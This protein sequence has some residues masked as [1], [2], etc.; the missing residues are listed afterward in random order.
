MR[1]LKLSTISLLAVLLLLLAFATTAQAT[2]R[3]HPR[4]YAVLVGAENAHRG[5][6]VMAFFPDSITIHVGDTVRWIQNSNEIHTVTFLGGG[7][8]PDLILPAAVLGLPEDPSPL[9]FNPTAVNR[10]AAP[11][12]L[13]DTTTFVN[14]GLM[15]REAGQYR[16]FALTFR[17]AGTYDYLCL[18]HGMMMSGTVR[19]VGA[20]VPVPSPG[21]ALARGYFQMARQF[22][23][24]P[25]VV[26]EAKA[27][28]KPDTKNPDGTT[29]HH[30]SIGFS[31]GQ[32][33]LMRFFPRR[34]LV[35]PGDTVVWEMSAS[36]DAPHTVTFLNGQTEPELVIPVAQASGPP[37]LYFN[38]GALFP[39]Q[40]AA[41]LTRTG[42]YNSGIMNP[43]PG[44][45]YTQVIG[46]VSPGP[47]PYL[48]LLHDTSGMRGKLVVRLCGAGAP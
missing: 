32:I 46:D 27:Q 31:S 7:P 15:G 17:A 16:S 47:L 22:A 23:L 2:T 13:S 18:V 25:A 34:A 28:I 3:H 45:T 40:P 37:V 30:V 38:P 39:A 35:R 11:G 48:C 20:R 14:S 19:V 10:A 41:D 26:R 43:I 29:T 36:N 33:D 1:A 42:L 6:D 9:V 12:G 24:A 5:I 21:L 44:T 8:A 4:T